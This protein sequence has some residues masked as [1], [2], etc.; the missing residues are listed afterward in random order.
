MNAKSWKIQVQQDTIDRL[1]K[2]AD[3]LGSAMTP[4]G[5]AAMTVFEISRIPA[6]DLWLALGAIRQFAPMDPAA[7]PRRLPGAKLEISR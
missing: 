5:I 3:E 2:I 1:A 7:A 6:K 4:N